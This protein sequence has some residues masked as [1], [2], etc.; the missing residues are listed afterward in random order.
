MDLV[1]GYMGYGQFNGRF[2]YVWVKG[3]HSFGVEMQ[4]DLFSPPFRDEWTGAA[5]ASYGF[6]W[7]G[8]GSAVGLGMKLWTGSTYG[9]GQSIAAR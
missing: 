1:L 2:E 7:N 4:D 8:V 3:K 9:H 5:E 6:D